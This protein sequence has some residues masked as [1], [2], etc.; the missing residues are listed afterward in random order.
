MGANGQAVVLLSGRSVTVTVTV[1]VTVT[2]IEGLAM[3][4]WS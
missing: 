4:R 1:M 3:E 2:V